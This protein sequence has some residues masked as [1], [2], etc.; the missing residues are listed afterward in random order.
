MNH[1]ISTRR[2]RWERIAQLYESGLSMA[3]IA[4]VMQMTRQGVNHA[5]KQQGVQVRPRG[6]SNGGGRR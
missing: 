6:G 3:E 5:L 4:R 1:Q 2:G